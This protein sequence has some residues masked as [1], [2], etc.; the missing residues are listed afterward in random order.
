MDS[1]FATD[2]P[3]REEGHVIF[4]TGQQI[5]LLGGPLYTTYK[6]LGAAK[7]A[8]EKNAKAV[9]WLE[10]NDADFEEISQ[11]SLIG[12]SG[13]LKHFVWEKKTG[14]ETSGS[15]LVDENLRVLLEKYFSAL[16]KTEDRDTLREWAMSAYQKDRSLGDASESLARELYGFLN[17]EFFRPDTQAFRDFSKPYLLKEALRTA[18]G[19]QANGFILDTR[20]GRS[21][22][23]AFFKKNGIFQTREGEKIDPEKFVLLPNVKTRSIVQD[24]FFAAREGGQPP[25]A[26]VAGPGEIAYLKDMGE[27]YAFQGVKPAEVIPRMSATLLEPKIRRLV[28]KSEIPIGVW[29]SEKSQDLLRQTM[30]LA[31]GEDLAAKE[32]RLET[33]FRSFVNEAKGLDFDTA[34]IEK[35]IYE[36]L[37]HVVG[38]KRREIKDRS[39]KELARSRMILGHLKPGGE[40]QERVLNVFQYMNGRGGTAF[41]RTIYDRY[42]S[43]EQ[44]FEI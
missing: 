26:Y 21:I 17:I 12:E 31:S 16:P 41:I 10:T 27:G 33:A 4:I 23:R 30:T 42:A 37:K 7:L 43:G 39:E 11:L 2:D 15:V 28:E 29:L 35:D 8:A 13:D 1:R 24:A 40:K 9:Y 22:R 19:V 14:G 36:T 18:E 38:K 34:R 5:G 44:V 3:L 6:V 25:L 20:G 32:T